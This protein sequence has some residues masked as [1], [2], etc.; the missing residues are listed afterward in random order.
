MSRVIYGVA[1]GSGSG[2][3]TVAAEIVARVRASR[4]SERASRVEQLLW[5]VDSPPGGG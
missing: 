1:D 3:S 2:T 5:A 4:V